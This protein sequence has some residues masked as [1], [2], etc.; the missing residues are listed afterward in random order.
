MILYTAEMELP[1]AVVAAFDAWYAHRH[2]PDLFA[3]GFA[4]CTSYRAV[5]G[6]M[7]VLSLYRLP[8]WEIFDSAA[9]KAIGRRDTYGGPIMAQ[10]SDKANTPYEHRATWLAGEEDGL[11][12]TEYATQAEW[13]A[14]LGI[15]DWMRRR[16][17][18]PTTSERPRGFPPHH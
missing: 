8:A 2:A 13:L 12:T 5:A 17:R 11:A 6:E 15:Q 14:S 7:N 9:Y 16:E 18:W 10:A 4:A 3:A 1:P